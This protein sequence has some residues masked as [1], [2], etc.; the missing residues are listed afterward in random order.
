MRSLLCVVFLVIVIVSMTSAAEAIKPAGWEVVIEVE[1]APFAV[2]VGASDAQRDVWTALADQNYVGIHVG[3]GNQGAIQSQVVYGSKTPI[4]QNIYL[5]SNDPRITEVR[6][7]WYTVGADYSGNG[8]YTTAFWPKS[9]RYSLCLLGIKNLGSF[10]APRQGW[11]T[12]PIRPSDWNK[13]YVISLQANN[14]K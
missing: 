13:G 1:G 12:R 3:I 9:V 11:L 10:N 7:H 5:W 2:S 4:N 6:V 14:P 8:Q